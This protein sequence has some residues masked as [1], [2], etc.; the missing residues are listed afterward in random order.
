[1]TPQTDFTLYNESCQLYLA[2]EQIAKAKASELLGLTNAD[3]AQLLPA[4]EQGLFIPLALYEDGSLNIRVAERE[5]TEQ[6]S[7]EWLNCTQWKLHIPSGTL[8]ISGGLSLFQQHL[9]TDSAE[10]HED[11]VCTV[12]VEPGWYLIKAYGYLPSKSVFPYEETEPEAI[13]NWF[14][15][16]RPGQE[17]PEWLQLWCLDNP[18]LD[19]G[20]NEEW[21]AHY[22]KIGAQ[23][24]KKLVDTLQERYLEYLFHLTPIQA[25]T[26][27]PPPVLNGSVLWWDARKPERCPIGLDVNFPDDF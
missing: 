13:G 15:R 10:Y 5:L 1:M 27:L 14:R 25:D 24:F 16:T 23:G 17:F 12:F 4:L 9:D 19:P 21:D 26:K 6:E 11:F 7:N 3:E 20:H 22:K 2:D 8:S 18:E